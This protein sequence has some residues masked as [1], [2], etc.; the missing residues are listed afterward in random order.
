MSVIATETTS[1][2]SGL[3]QLVLSFQYEKGENIFPFIGKE[4]GYG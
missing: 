4:Y 1:E 2:K 3:K